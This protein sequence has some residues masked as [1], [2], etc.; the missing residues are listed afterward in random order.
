MVSF[1][2][3]FLVSWL[4]QGE[5]LAPRVL[6]N[7]TQPYTMKIKNKPVGDDDPPRPPNPPNPFKL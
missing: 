3:V 6:L 5:G 7:L 2:I 4:S 1:F